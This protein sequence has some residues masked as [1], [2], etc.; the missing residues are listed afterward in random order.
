M[1]DSER[2]KGKRRCGG[3]R[4]SCGIFGGGGGGEELRLSI[5]EGK[6]VKGGGGRYVIIYGGV[7]TTNIRSEH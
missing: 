1:S 4:G 2:K 3:R 5:R 6:E 7:M